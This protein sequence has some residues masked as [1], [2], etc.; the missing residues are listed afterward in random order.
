MSVSSSPVCALRGEKKL[1]EQGYRMICA[2]RHVSL[3]ADAVPEGSMFRVGNL[4]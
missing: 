3:A 4:L 2:Q 1:S